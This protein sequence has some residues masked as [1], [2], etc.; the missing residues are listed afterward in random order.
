M[1]TTDVTDGVI[2]PDWFGAIHVRGEDAEQFL[3][4][5][6]SN[7]TPASDDPATILAAWCDAKGR[8]RALFRVIRTSNQS[9]ILITRSELIP[10]LVKTLQMFVLRAHV[11]IIADKEMTWLGVYGDSIERLATSDELP[12]TSGHWAS[13]AD[14]I[15]IR[16][17]GPRRRYLV[18]GTPNSHQQLANEPVLDADEWILDDIRAGCPD[19]L[20]A[21]QNQFVPQMLNLHWLGGIDFNK[22]CYPGQEVVARLQFRGSLKRRVYRATLS[23]PAEPGAS[24]TAGDNSAGTVLESALTAGDKRELL[25]VIQTDAAKSALSIDGNPLQLQTL[26]YSTE[27]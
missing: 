12:S 19:I 22:G 15:V 8:A 10:N 13:L 5:Q 16:M 20:T 23:G 14:T 9:F 3:S 1:T 7:T 18:M 26:P 25:A 24:V 27:D 4:A 2:H 21:T 6:L 11:E 17:N